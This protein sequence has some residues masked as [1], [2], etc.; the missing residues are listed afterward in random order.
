MKTTVRDF[1]LDNMTDLNFERLVDMLVMNKV[2][3][4][5]LEYEMENTIFEYLNK[6][7]S[8]YTQNNTFE[9]LNEIRKMSVEM[10][11]EIEVEVEFP[12]ENPSVESPEVPIIDS[13]ENDTEELELDIS[14]LYDPFTRPRIKDKS[15]YTSFDQLKIAF[16]SET[17][18]SIE[19]NYIDPFDV[20][21][22]N[23]QRYVYQEKNRIALGLSNFIYESL[24]YTREHKLK[25]NFEQFSNEDSH[26]K[27]ESDDTFNHGYCVHFLLDN[28]TRYIS[29]RTRRA[30]YDEYQCEFEIIPPKFVDYNEL[31]EDLSSWEYTYILAPFKAYLN[32][33]LIVPDVSENVLYDILEQLIDLLVY[34]GFTQI[35][36]LIEVNRANGIYE[37]NIRYCHM[38]PIT[39]V[40]DP[41]LEEFLPL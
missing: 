22:T 9:I 4:C 30:Y 5:E 26:V 18:E 13:S 8:S 34:Q 24:H 17:Y 40:D 36:Q 19:K 28:R 31:Q 25:N 29:D 23:Y 38:L 10:E 21:T 20:N 41:D 14:D 27:I 35:K 1:I 32:E 2:F 12:E 39:P 11:I 7:K 3:E 15:E 37:D 6:Q 33:E 16:L